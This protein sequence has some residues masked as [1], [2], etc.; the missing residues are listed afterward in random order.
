MKALVATDG[1]ELASEALKRLGNFVS[2]AGT[3]LILL[4]A[5]PNP[6]SARYGLEPVYLDLTLIET[7]LKQ[8]AESAIQGGRTLLEAQGFQNIQTRTCQG[9]A[10]TVILDAAAE[11][12][13]DLVVVGSHGRSGWSRFLMGSVSSR[14]IDHAP[15]SVLVLKPPRR[16][17]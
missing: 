13:V 9:D 11:E 15:C 8:D 6:M 17:S 14:V 4:T 10:A 3:E 2:P 7:Q 1:S 16:P 12:K 5:F